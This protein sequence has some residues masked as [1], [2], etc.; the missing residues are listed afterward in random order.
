MVTLAEAE[1]NAIGLILRYH[2]RIQ[3]TLPAPTPIPGALVNVAKYLG[4]L[5][6]RIWQ[7]MQDIVQYSEY[8]NCG[9]F[10]VADYR[11]QIS[12]FDL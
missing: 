2:S 6:F 11:L 7:K 4:N 5:R 10:C 9:T 1:K 12:P 3:C 8:P